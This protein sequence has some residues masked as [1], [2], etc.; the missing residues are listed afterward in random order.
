VSSVNEKDFFDQKIFRFFRSFFDI[1]LKDAF[2]FSNA[3]AQ[4][5]VDAVFL[6]CFG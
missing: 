4:A 2:D 1:H 6:Q 5:A 3:N